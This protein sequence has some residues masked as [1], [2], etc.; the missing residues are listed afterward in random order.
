MGTVAIDDFF[1]GTR[2]ALA[3]GTTTISMWNINSIEREREREKERE[4]ES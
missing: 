1:H 2:A 4:R 3:G